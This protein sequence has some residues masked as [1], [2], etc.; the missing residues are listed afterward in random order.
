M[1]EANKNLIGT[2]HSKCCKIFEVFL[3]I[4]GRYILKD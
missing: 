2:L 4:L 1:L 3:A